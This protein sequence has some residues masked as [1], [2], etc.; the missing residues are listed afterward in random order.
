[1]AEETHQPVT[2]ITS[3]M[4]MVLYRTSYEHPNGEPGGNHAYRKEFCNYR[5]DPDC[6]LWRWL[7]AQSLTDYHVLSRLSCCKLYVKFA[8]GRAVFPSLRQMGLNELREDK[9]R[10]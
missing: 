9:N 7:C 6:W 8:D 3:R 10:P 1:M 2:A 5:H 4:E